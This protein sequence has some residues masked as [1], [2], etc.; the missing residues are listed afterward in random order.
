MLGS[1]LG[2]EALI[3]ISRGRE[4]SYP[5]VVGTALVLGLVSGGI[6][7]IEIDTWLRDGAVLC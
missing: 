4:G 6:D 7:H 2:L 1:A 3:R 5:E